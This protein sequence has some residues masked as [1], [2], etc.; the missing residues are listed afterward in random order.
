MAMIFDGFR[1]MGEAEAFAGKAREMF[2]LDADAYTERRDD[3]DPF[4]FELTA[5]V[6]Y[7]ERAEYEGTERQVRLMVGRYNGEFAG[8]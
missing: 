4:P 1:T 5:P 8:T 7:V 2:G 6:V 3:I